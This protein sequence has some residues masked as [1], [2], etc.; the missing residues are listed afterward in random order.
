MKKSE[1]QQIIREEIIKTLN[2]NKTPYI[3]VTYD[4]PFDTTTI[5]G[6]SKDG[7]FKGIT[8]KGNYESDWKKK[9]DDIDSA[10]R[11]IKNGLIQYKILDIQ[12]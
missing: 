2:E 12:N 4:K 7:N 9:Y 11:N 5:Q 1:L 6:V 10:I 8:V 3:Q